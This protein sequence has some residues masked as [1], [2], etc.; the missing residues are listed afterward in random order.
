MGTTGGALSI[1]ATGSIMNSSTT[2]HIHI[3]GCNFKYN[4]ATTA[5][6]AIYI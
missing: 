4:L 6:G 3:T 5:G 2:E 1:Q